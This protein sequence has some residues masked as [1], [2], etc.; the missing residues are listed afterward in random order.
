M[1]Q[2][3]EDWENG[4]VS[5]TFEEDLNE[6]YRDYF[7]DKGVFIK[8]REKNFLAFAHFVKRFLTSINYNK[9]DYSPKVM[10]TARLSTVFSHG[11]EAYARACVDNYVGKLKARMEYRDKKRAYREK[12][13]GN[14]DK[15][16]DKDK[17]KEEEP[18]TPPTVGAKWSS[19]GNGNQVNGWE[20]AGID[21]YSKYA[22]EILELRAG[23]NTGT[24]LEDYLIKHF[25]GTLKEPK[26]KQKE[27]K[28]VVQAYEDTNALAALFAEV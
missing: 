8:E 13:P 3:A 18:P 7:D 19:S 6:H 25:K 27:K 10:K 4:K 1:F 23:H 9:N 28:A 21:Q 22:K 2:L 12:P 20:K 14:K 5:K 11:D 24:K 16:K 26:R 17:D 15:D